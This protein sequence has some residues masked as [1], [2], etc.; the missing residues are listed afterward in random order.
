[1]KI[2]ACCA[3]ALAMLAGAAGSANGAVVIS[4]VYGAGGNTGALFNADYVE[5]FNNGPTTTLTNFSLQYASA[6]GTTWSRCNIPSLT[7]A[8]NS[9][10]L[11]QVSAVGTNGAALTADFVAS[12][13]SGLLSMS[14][15]SGKIALVSDQVALAS[16]PAGTMLDFVG[17]GTATCFEGSGPTTTLS[18]TLAALRQ[19]GGCTDTN[20]NSSDFAVQAPNPRNSSTAPNACGGFTD[21][22]SNGIDDL[23]EIAGNPA[24]DCNTN[25]QLD[26]CEI[27]G[28][29]SL[30]CNGN[31][32]I[33]SCD[34]ASNASLDCD[35]DGTIDSC[36][37]ASFAD[38]DGG[39]C[40]APNGVLDSCENAAG[41][42]CNA[43]SVRDC[44]EFKTYVLTDV[45]QN[46][47]YDVCEGA[48]VVETVENATVQPSTQTPPGVR[49]AVNFFNIEGINN[50]NF[51]SYGGIRFD[52][53]AFASLGGNVG[54]VYL[55]LT[56]R[57]AAFT[58]GG[59]PTD[60]DNVEMHYSNMDAVNLAPGTQTTVFENFA[61]DFSDAQSLGTYKFVRGTNPPPALPFSGSG[62]GNGTL[63]YRLLFDSSAS[64]TPAQAAV[65]AEVASATGSLTILLTPIAGQDY[66][67]AT[68]AGYTDSLYRGPT[69]VVFPTTG[70][71]CDSLDFNNDG[72]SPDT[73]DIDDFLSVFGGGP[74]STDPTPGCNDLD[75]NNDGVAPD[76]TDI[77]AFLSVFG[78][79]PCL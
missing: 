66:V 71:N 68:Y 59:L 33:D 11:V 37:I 29:P 22:N 25:T 40:G 5:L 41:D 17:Y 54:K 4:Q 15:T 78:G 56:Q 75:F 12:S 3:A 50:G 28:N 2:K 63:E 67:A 61:T 32:V 77:D 13:A 31:S 23:I 27:A 18:A 14:G 42:D 55:Q 58:A 30:D 45:N 34:I 70:P 38:L 74:C 20:N 57:N 39:L 64:P 43:N 65:G 51:A 53:T 10:A 52:N 44:W 49:T 47:I 24:L 76:T 1:M 62:T 6:T 73:G 69:L 8:A 36:E 26:S 21:C 16:C 72:V 35:T 19:N 79:G 7:I 60:P 48:V 9:Y 46:G